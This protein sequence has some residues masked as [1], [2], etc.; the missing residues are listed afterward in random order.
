MKK[1]VKVVLTGMLFFVFVSCVREEREDVVDVEI[2]NYTDEWI[3][4]R[5]STHNQEAGTREG[6]I[7]PFEVL[8]AKLDFSNVAKTDGSYSLQF[9]YA[10]SDETIKKD[11]GYYTNGF[12]LDSM[13]YISIYTDSVAI[14]SKARDFSS[15]RYI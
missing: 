2:T 14:R 9:K 15:F 3:S 4:V 12:P 6:T 1:P 13:F 11:F 5:L 7:A 10:D 8:N